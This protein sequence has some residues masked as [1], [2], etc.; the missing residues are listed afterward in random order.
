M[1]LIG[2]EGI[3]AGWL[4]S[5]PSPSASGRRA[6]LEP[7]STL[8]DTTGLPDPT[9][10]SA[11]PTRVRRHRPAPKPLAWGLGAGACALSLFACKSAKA[12]AESADEEVYAILEARRL[13]LEADLGSVDIDPSTDTLRLRL[14]AEGEQA[15]PIT[16]NLVQALEVSAENSRDYQTRK[17]VLY[18]T[19][20]DLT[21][22]RWRF[23]VQE[24]GTLGALVTG[25][26]EEAQD[27]DLNGNLRLSKVLGTGAR[28]VGD[29]GFSMFR[30]LTT[31]DAFDFVSDLSLSVTQPL[32][33]GF[34]AR[35]VMEPLTQAERDVVYAVR[36]FERYRRTF[37][38]DVTSRYLRLLQAADAVENQ[39]V[40]YESLQ[41]LRRR[42]E[43]WGQAGRMSDV[44]VDQARQQEV[45]ARDNVIQA[46][47]DYQ[48]Q[49]DDFK[50][51]IG[52]QPDADIRI[53]PDALERMSQA[54]PEALPF[55]DAD[56]LSDFALLWRLDHLTAL[57]QVDDA[58]RQS[59]VAAD[60]LRN[61]LDFAARADL[62]SPE[63]ETDPLDLDLDDATWQASLQ[64]DL[65]LD[66]MQ[67]RNSY[68]IALINLQGAERDA[69]QSEDAIRLGVRDALREA[70]RTLQSWI[71]QKGQVALNERRMESAR[72][73]L[74]AGRASTRDIL[75][76][77]GD[78]LTAKN[79]AT[80]ALIDQY[81]AVLALWRDLEVLRLGPDG[82]Y[83]DPEM[84]ALLQA[85]LP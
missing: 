28:I 69:L 74:E 26:G 2:R 77:T 24:V 32:L 10:L 50:F 54:E 17:E 14:E 16:L 42:N 3:L 51:L 19:A 76:A 55:D 11:R 49:L 6:D 83:P 81:L 39:R 21:L 30:V 44:E 37:V 59:Y 64:A 1:L 58:R 38:F 27:A 45:D 57:D 61:R 4:P 80:R 78:L 33:G 20:L 43:A 31:G 40:T 18:L 5:R 29:I 52:L 68:R 62:S 12:H 56:L 75:E 36:A 65:A 72:L 23:K 79:S 46:E 25:T 47:Q 7:R 60:A 34:G 15:E 41:E 48:S 35:I 67:E 63:G 9:S 82:P 8:P 66:R 71:L 84:L 70:D 13:E 73:Q 22:E 53:S 85:Q